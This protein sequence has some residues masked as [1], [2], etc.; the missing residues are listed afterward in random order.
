[1]STKRCRVV[2]VSQNRPRK[3]KNRDRE[4]NL[5]IGRSKKTNFL[6]ISPVYRAFFLTSFFWFGRFYDIVLSLGHI[7]SRSL[8]FFLKERWI[9]GSSRKLRVGGERTVRPMAESTTCSTFVHPVAPCRYVFSPTQ[10]LTATATDRVSLPHIDMS[11][12]H[13]STTRFAASSCM[14]ARSSASSWL[15]SL[16]S[17]LILYIKEHP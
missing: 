14:P 17:T 2:Q 15:L 13:E 10:L 1:V 4:S 16:R 6:P 3:P 11:N 5:L 8:I 9:D 12:D 7:T